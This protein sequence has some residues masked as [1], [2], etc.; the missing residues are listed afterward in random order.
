MSFNGIFKNRY[1]LVFNKRYSLFHHVYLSHITNRSITTLSAQELHAKTL[2]RR[3]LEKDACGVGM[4]AN[5]NN[6]FNRNTITSANEMLVNMAHRGG[7][8]VDKKCGDGAGILTTIP[9]KFLQKSIQQKLP[10]IFHYGTGN[11]FFGKDTSLNRQIKDIFQNIIENDFG[12]KLLCWRSI[13]TNNTNLGTQS[14]ETEPLMEQIFIT[15][16]ND[17]HMLPNALFERQ[18]LLLRNVL[19]NR[20]E[21]ELCLSD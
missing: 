18:L 14:L 19:L 16:N 8:G 20:I 2:Y 4:I 5:L 21:K 10:D 9:H 12:F 15:Q 1:L 17:N 11:V 13:P 3:T 7:E 6:D